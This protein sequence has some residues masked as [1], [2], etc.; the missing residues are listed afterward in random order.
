[1]RLMKLA[2]VGSPLTWRGQFGGKASL[3]ELGA[4]AMTGAPI[5][6]GT[7]VRSSVVPGESPHAEWLLMVVVATVGLTRAN[8]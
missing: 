1:M 4:I 6:R 5:S 8:S 3:A 2:V 7:P